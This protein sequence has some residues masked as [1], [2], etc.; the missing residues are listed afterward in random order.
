MK[1][2]FAPAVALM[3]RLTYPR[4]FGLI[5]LL[6]TL[7]LGLVTFFLVS[8]LNDRIAFS[9]KE[10]L[11]NE[12]LRPVQ[13][14]ASDLRD[15]RGLTWARADQQNTPE[16]LRRVDERLQRDIQDIDAADRKLGETLRTTPLWTAIK[17]KYRTLQGSSI[18]SPSVDPDNRHTALIADLIALKSQVGD[19]SNLIL[20]PDLD[21]YYLMELT[22][23]RLPQLT[24]QIGQARSFSSGLADRET[25]SELDEFRL[26]HLSSA[27]A[28]P[29][30]TRR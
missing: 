30:V 8:E 3:N 13:Q 11:G 2:C 23:N 1:S 26:R 29:G 6:F 28:H 4:K 15:H 21:S 24:E 20:D 10:Q 22:V 27:I 7:P 16:E 17:G 5:G 25:I 19:Q 18:T 14:F 12:Y 9:A